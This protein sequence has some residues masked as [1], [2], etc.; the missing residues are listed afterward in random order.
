MLGPI[1]IDLGSPFE[2][3][4]YVW[5]RETSTHLP[6]NTQRETHVGL[7]REVNS[8]WHRGAPFRQ[9]QPPEGG[10]V[11]SWAREYSSLLLLLL[12]P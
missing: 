2:T 3:E 11:V 7:G 6:S 1:S 5:L 8:W 10:N 4:A 9:R 12:L